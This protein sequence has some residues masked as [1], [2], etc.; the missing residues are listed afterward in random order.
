MDEQGHADVPSAFSEPP[1]T[2]GPSRR[3]VSF[4]GED[5]TFDIPARRQLGPLSELME[6]FERVD[7]VECR[8]SSLD[9]HVSKITESVDDVWSEVA[10]ARHEVWEVRKC[11][12]PLPTR[13]SINDSGTSEYFVFRVR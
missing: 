8:I 12:V 2:T 4:A 10:V 9:Q 11:T 7:A 5:E 6:L 13:D 3:C 1:E